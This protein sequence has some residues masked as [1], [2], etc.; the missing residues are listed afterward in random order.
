MQNQQQ[1]PPQEQQNA[2][3][4]S[5]EELTVQQHPPQGQ[6]TQSPLL[7]ND[8]FS[9]TTHLTTQK[10]SRKRKSGS[11][12]K[13]KNDEK[14]PMDL[15]ATQFEEL[16]KRPGEKF[17]AYNV[18][19]PQEQNHYLV[20][21]IGQPFRSKKT[22]TLKVGG[23]EFP[24]EEG[25]W[26]LKGQ[27]LERL[28]RKNWYT[29]T[30]NQ[31]E[32][33]VRLQSVLNINVTMHKYGKE[34]GFNRGTSRAIIQIADER[35]A[36]RMDDEVRKGLINECQKRD[37]MQEDQDQDRTKKKKRKVCFDA[38]LLLISSLDAQLICCRDKVMSRKF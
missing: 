8:D 37:A 13:K 16:S 19:D 32:C 1:P 9:M 18:D 20:K 12:S 30:V 17:L 3:G 34:N 25:D 31:G 5:Q 36:Y 24:V 14:S 11:G 28:P 10:P 23:N 33:V 38:H 2:Q 29:L 22:E 27:W 4:S 7:L 35:G 26:L 21:W 6:T 15:M